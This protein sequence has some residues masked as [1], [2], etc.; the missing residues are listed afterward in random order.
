MSH[1][2]IT[3]GCADGPVQN[4]QVINAFDYH[5][6][7]VPE[8]P[9]PFAHIDTHVDIVEPI[10]THVHQDVHAHVPAPVHA[11]I[12]VHAHAHVPVVTHV[13]SPTLVQTGTH[14]VYEVVGKV[15]VKKVPIRPGIRGRILGPKQP[16]E[17]WKDVH[18]RPNGQRPSYAYTQTHSHSM[19]ATPRS[20]SLH[21]PPRRSWYVPPPAAALPPPLSGVGHAHVH[22]PVFD[23]GLAPTIDLNHCAPYAGGCNAPSPA[24]AATFPAD[25]PFAVNGPYESY[26]PEAEQHG[27]VAPNL[28]G[29]APPTFVDVPLPNARQGSMANAGSVPVPGPRGWNGPGTHAGTVGHGGTYGA[30]TF[31]GAQSGTIGGGPYSGTDVHHHHGSV[32]EGYAGYGSIASTDAVL[33]NPGPAGTCFEGDGERYGDDR[34]GEDVEEALFIPVYSGLERQVV[35]DV[36]IP[37]PPPSPGAPQSRQAAPARNRGYGS[38]V[39]ARHRGARGGDASIMA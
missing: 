38:Y 8:H 35:G 10:I 7:A 13:A 30:G 1:Y 29:G 4:S 28:H 39:A 21:A 2:A 14:T 6:H 25:A 5:N 22:G 34:Y 12:P 3:P 23:E 16:V 20:R 31:G 18:M 32:A 26:C 37:P 27:R 11:H 19:M 9:H 15:K 36:T 17:V 24:D 33:H